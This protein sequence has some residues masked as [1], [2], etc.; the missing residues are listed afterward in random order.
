MAEAQAVRR[1]L[2]AT[3]F[4]GGAERALTVGT[5]LAQAFH[6]TIDILHVCPPVSHVSA[7]P[8]S[9]VFP[10]A[11]S[12]TDLETIGRS[13]AEL[14]GRVSEAG[15]ECR[16]AIVEGDPAKMIIAQTASVGGDL[17]VMGT[18][19]RTGLRRLIMGSVAEATLRRAVT[20][21]LVVPSED[22]AA[23]VVAPAPGG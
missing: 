16:T 8:V 1:I 2:V 6:A 12:P 17:I 9:G 4:S 11:P 13:L 14:A 5:E 7:Q 15:V 20:P 21:V 10:A 18:R 19:G 22:S 23:P 3:D